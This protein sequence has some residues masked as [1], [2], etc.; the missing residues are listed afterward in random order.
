V[1]IGAPAAAA[2]GPIATSDPAGRNAAAS[3]AASAATTPLRHRLAGS[4]TSTG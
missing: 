2:A 4:G 1:A 3:P